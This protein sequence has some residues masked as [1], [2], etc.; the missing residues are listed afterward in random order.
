MN[1]YP[2][3]VGLIHDD[4]SRLYEFRS[5][6]LPGQKY[7][8][9]RQSYYRRKS[10]ETQIV[11]VSAEKLNIHPIFIDPVESLYMLRK[12]V[13]NIFYY[14]APRKCTGSPVI[15]EYICI[16]SATVFL[17][18]YIYCNSPFISLSISKRRALFRADKWIQDYSATKM[19][20]ISHVN[21]QSHF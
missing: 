4:S 3:R 6:P 5:G 19:W 8:S 13:V 12:R 11:I 21:N 10:R 18:C 9:N 7:T 1:H 20:I 2:W 14:E 15:V 17:Q 16:E